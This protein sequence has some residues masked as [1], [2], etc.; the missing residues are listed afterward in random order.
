M[1]AVD[2]MP[3]GVQLIGQVNED[4]RMTA[5]AAWLHQNIAPVRVAAA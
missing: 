2:G 5:M 4:A 1:L 3:V